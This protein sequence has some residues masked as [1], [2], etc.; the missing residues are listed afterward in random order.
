MCGIFGIIGEPNATTLLMQGLKRMEYRGYDSSGICIVDNNEFIRRRAVGELSN[1]EP[2]VVNLPDSECGIAHTRWATHG[3][4]TEDNAHPHMSPKL[5]V[6]VVHNGIIEN[7]VELRKELSSIDKNI[8]FKSDT[9]SEIIAH[10]FSNE[11]KNSG[12]DLKK[13]KDEE[14]I[15]LSLI[16]I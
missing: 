10:L 8:T 2:L 12:L 1:L 7:E 5:D 13:S 14:F 6:A 11:I 9:D 15:N 3:P 4:P 16:H